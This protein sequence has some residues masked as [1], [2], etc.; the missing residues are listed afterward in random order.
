MIASQVPLYHLFQVLLQVLWGRVNDICSSKIFWKDLSCKYLVILHH[1]P[2]CIWLFSMFFTYLNVWF[3]KTAVS[4]AL[5]VAASLPRDRCR[6]SRCGRRRTHLLPCTAAQ[7][8]FNV[9]LG[10]IVVVYVKN[11]R[12]SFLWLA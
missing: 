8:I 1:S 10:H 3:L 6:P 4:T 7:S 5:F 9:E 11:R 2:T 12:N